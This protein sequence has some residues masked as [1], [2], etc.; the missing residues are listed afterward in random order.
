MAMP[1][2]NFKG[3]WNTSFGASVPP[4]QYTKLFLL[5]CSQSQKNVLRHWTKHHR[6]SLILFNLVLEPQHITKHFAMSAT[7]SL[8]LIW[9]LYGHSWRS[10]LRFFAMMYVKDQVL[11]NDFGDTFSDSF[12][13]N[14]SQHP[15][16]QDILQSA[17][18]QIRDF[19]ASRWGYLLALWLEILVSYDKFGF[20]AD[21]C[22][23][24]NSFPLLSKTLWS[25]INFC[26]SI[27]FSN[28]KKREHKIIICWF[29]SSHVDSI[30]IEKPGIIKIN[31]IL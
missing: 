2:T 19:M 31:A 5:T 14:L 17:S 27:L 1:F 18:S 6:E 4:P 15:H 26:Y 28:L 25:R 16:C 22:L 8:C 13:Q 11:G 30:Y 3:L 12:K 21:K 10:F 7:V 9:I 23:M 20:S 24:I 29:I